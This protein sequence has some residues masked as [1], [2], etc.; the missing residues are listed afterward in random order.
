[1]LLILYNDTLYM[2]KYHTDFKVTNT[3]AAVF[4]KNVKR[5]FMHILKQNK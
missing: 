3:A 2:V 5:F 4:H 1:M